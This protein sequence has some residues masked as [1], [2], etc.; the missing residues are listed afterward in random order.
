MFENLQFSR[1]TLDAEMQSMMRSSF[2]EEWSPILRVRSRGEGEQ[3][4]MYMREAGT[5]V[6]VAFV[7]INKENAAIV[8]ATFNPDKLADFMENPKI[9][10]VSLNENKPE[11]NETTEPK[12][13][14]KDAEKSN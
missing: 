14:D 11:N 1:E 5:S 2:G 3:V 6:K 13:T 7:T 10:G 4:Y 12:D 9:F 8:R